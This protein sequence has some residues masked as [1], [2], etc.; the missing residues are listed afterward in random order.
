MSQAILNIA[1]NIQVNNHRIVGQQVSRSGLLR[2]A[3]YPTGQPWVF[4]VT[5]HQYLSYNNNRDTLQVIANNDRSEVFPIRFNDTNSGS[6]L[7]GWFTRLRGDPLETTLTYFSGKT[8]SVFRGAGACPSGFVYRAG[9]LL[10]LPQ[11]TAGGAYVYQV[12]NDVPYT[13]GI[14]NYTV[15]LHRPVIGN[16]ASNN[17]I[18]NGPDVVFAMVVEKYPNM[19]LQPSNGYDAY[20]GWDSN[21]IFRENLV[22]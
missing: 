11:T 6:S 8:I 19:V 22:G 13:F 4:T 15:N 12:A 3:E 10:Q 18:A 20:V 1:S 2:T 14:T 7:L 9:D 16:P 5:P 17:T 21:F